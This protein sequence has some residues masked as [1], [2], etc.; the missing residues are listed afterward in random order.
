MLIDNKFIYVSLPRRGSTSFHYSCILHNF[1]IK[2][3][4]PNWEIENSKIDFNNINESD[5]MNYI[6]HGHEPLNEIYRKFG[7]NFPVIAVNRN[8]HNTFYSLFK[9]AIFDLERAG[10]NKVSQHFSNLSSNDLFFWNT[11]DLVSKKRRW[12]TIND[13]L[14]KN[15]LISDTKVIPKTLS[16]YSE[17]YIINILD[18]LLTP[19]SFWHNHNK[20]IIWF[21]MDNLSEM[22]EWISDITKKPFKLKKVNSSKHI[23]CNLK[24]DNEFVKKYNSI[25][26]YYDLPKTNKTLI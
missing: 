26:D 10:F 24:L 25:Y 14:Y 7:F 21:D 16:L 5:I 13:Y 11:D 17:E 23:D 2:S 4:E 1:E 3:T 15:E 9:H 6:A 22:E 20:N 8:R 12:E 19:A 18:I